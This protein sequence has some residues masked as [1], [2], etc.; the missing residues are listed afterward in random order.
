MVA[1]T[2]FLRPLVLSPWEGPCR[3]IGDGDLEIFY[4]P[5]KFG[6]TTHAPFTLKGVISTARAHAASPAGPRAVDG[7][8]AGWAVP[9]SARPHL[10]REAQLRRPFQI[11]A[12]TPLS[13]A[14]RGSNGRRRGG[15]AY[16][17]YGRPSNQSRPLSRPWPACL[18]LGTR[19]PTWEGKAVRGHRR[20]LL[21]ARW[22]PE[23]R[24]V[25][26][27]SRLGE[28]VGGVTAQGQVIQGSQGRP[29]ALSMVL[30]L[31][32]QKSLSSGKSR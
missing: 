13:T 10:P 6:L 26:A 21:E 9:A 31:S 15:S 25:W 7:T 19:N 8:A 27:G 3:G 4:C 32:L 30:V 28:E 20:L 23:S 2:H 29:A 22:T 14:P 16:S 18:G 5:W 1:D 17:T 12:G 11:E 24:W